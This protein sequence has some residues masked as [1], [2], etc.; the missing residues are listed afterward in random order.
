MLARAV[1]V[2]RVYVKK[3]LAE[4]RNSHQRYSTQSAGSRWV[5]ARRFAQAMKSAERPNSSP[6]CAAKPPPPK[7]PSP[8]LVVNQC[9]DDPRD[10]P[11]LPPDEHAGDTVD[12]TMQNL[13]ARVAEL[14]AEAHYNRDLHLLAPCVTSSYTMV[15]RNLRSDYPRR[16]LPFRYSSW[17]DLFTAATNETTRFDNFDDDQTRLTN[18]MAQIMQRMGGVTMEHWAELQELRRIRNELSHPRLD[19]ARVHR[20]IQ[21]RWTRHSAGDALK[22]I[23]GY[24][25]TRGGVVRR[26]MFTGSSGRGGRQRSAYKHRVQGPRVGWGNISSSH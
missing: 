24:L 20:T 16:G 12:H 10:Q 3:S 19:D 14:E 7:I 25:A 2:S 21:A 17:V 1:P 6:L 4:L 9:I 5:Q 23:T 22:H 11:S 8:T 18:D 13:R 15:F 26:K